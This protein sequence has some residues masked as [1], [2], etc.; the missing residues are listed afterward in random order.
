MEAGA[1]VPDRDRKRL[2]TAQTIAGF[3]GPLRL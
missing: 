1:L 3:R 2:L